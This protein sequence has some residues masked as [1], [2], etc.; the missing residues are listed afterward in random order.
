MGKWEPMITKEK[1][2]KLRLCYRHNQHF[3]GETEV[4][5]QV[6][7]HNMKGEKQRN[8]QQI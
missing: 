4:I 1:M 8:E 7:N 2:R 3:M 6:K 5:F